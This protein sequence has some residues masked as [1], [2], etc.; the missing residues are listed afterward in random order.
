MTHS[1]SPLLLRR[2]CAFTAIELM[3]VVAIIAI[4]IA[5][6]LPAVQQARETAR[7]TQCANN[8]LQ[9]GIAL[10]SYHHTH[11]TLPP[12]VCDHVGPVKNDGQG[13]KLSWLVQLLPY[14]DEGN[15]YNR[16]DFARGAFDQ[17]DLELNTY[18]IPLLG[19][20]SSAGTSSY[21]GCH[22]DVE[23]P[24]DVTNNGCLFL[25][26]RVRFRD[27]TDGSRHTILLG[28]TGVSDSWLAGTSSMLRNTGGFTDLV[29]E[30]YQTMQRNYYDAPPARQEA[31]DDATT[32]DLDPLLR[33]GGFGSAHGAGANFCFADGNVRFVSSFIDETVLQRIA[34]RHDGG[35]VGSF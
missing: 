31:T 15:L 26:S 5:L 32:A 7:R 28:E 23:T 17:V 6:L 20:P 9:L 24:I 3:V 13:Y 10:H 1:R 27:I 8:M 14:L 2:R 35:L 19:C 11:R 22:N 4:L 29:G 33:V 12:G 21:G 30:N 18:R 34:N 25:N 16:I